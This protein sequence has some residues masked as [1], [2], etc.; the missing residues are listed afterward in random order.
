[1]IQGCNGSL[2]IPGNTSILL[3]CN[4]EKE[5]KYFMILL[6]FFQKKNNMRFIFSDQDEATDYIIKNYIS[7]PIHIDKSTQNQTILVKTYSSKFA[8]FSAQNPFIILI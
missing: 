4:G 2:I 6:L 1:M 3:I 5:F 8:F 7:T